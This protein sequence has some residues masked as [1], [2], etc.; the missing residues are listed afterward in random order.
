MSLFRVR[1]G[2]DFTLLSLMPKRSDM[3]TMESAYPYRR[4][5]M[6]LFSDLED[7][8]KLSMILAVYAAAY[9]AS[10]ELPDGIQSS[11]SLSNNA[12]TKIDFAIMLTYNNNTGGITFH[13]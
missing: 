3:E 13:E 10:T 6:I 4:T 7:A 9:S 2:E 11:G 1:S 5:N 8:K 12:T